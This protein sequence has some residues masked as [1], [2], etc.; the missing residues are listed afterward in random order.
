MILVTG[1]AGYIGSHIVKELILKKYQVIVID[2]LSTGHKEA[3][4][5]EATFIEGD[6]GDNQLLEDVFTRFHVDAVIHLAALCYVHESVIHP[7]KYYE[8]NV[9]NSLQLVKCML[10]HNVLK[11]IASSTCAT[12]GLP[13]TSVLDEKHPTH[14]INPYGRSKLMVEQMLADFS[15][16]HGLSYISLR[17]FNVSGAHPSREIGEDHTPE[18]HLIPSILNH[19]AEGSKELKIYGSD[20]PTKDGTCVRDF[21]DVNDI[22]DAHI[23]ALDSI[24]NT[25]N[26]QEVYNIGSERGYSVLEVIK[27]CEKVTGQK[28]H[29]TSQPR[30]AGDPPHLVASSTKI[31]SSLGWKPHHQLEDMI[32]SHWEWMKRHPD[33]YQSTP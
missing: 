30:R 10:K 12:Y 29:Y 19:I 22:A 26:Q 33:G 27:A 8:N 5:K 1:G 18:T 2:N 3:I 16:A 6:I 21:I 17:Y 32:S 11:I 14:P 24:L 28:V 23:R 31:Q 13:T 20:Y 7:E 25:S 9:A 4:D 15:R